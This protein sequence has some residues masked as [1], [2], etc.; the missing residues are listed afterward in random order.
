MIS[1]HNFTKSIYIKSLSLSSSA[2]IKMSL[3][4]EDARHFP[5]SC[6]NIGINTGYYTLDTYLHIHVNVTN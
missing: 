4:E 2:V 6:M 1:S 5:S 3:N